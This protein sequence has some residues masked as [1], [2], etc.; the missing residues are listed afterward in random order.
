VKIWPQLRNALPHDAP[1]AVTQ[2]NLWN[3]STIRPLLMRAGELT[4]VEKGERRVLFLIDPGRGAVA[5]QVTSTLYVGFQLLMPGETAPATNIP[6]CRADTGCN[7]PRRRP[8]ETFAARNVSKLLNEGDAEPDGAITA[9]G[10]GPTP[11]APIAMGYVSST[12]SA[13]GVQ[14]LAE[15][16]GQ[17]LSLRV[18]VMPF[19]PKTYKR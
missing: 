3:Y 18:A 5:M 17:G 7:A 2:P 12:L 1:K 13:N 4:P 19:V 9:G 8:S 14:F 15:E 10:F 6:E 11:H 16:R